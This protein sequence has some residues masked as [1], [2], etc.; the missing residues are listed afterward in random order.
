MPFAAFLVVGEYENQHEFMG[1]SSN[2]KECLDIVENHCK[3]ATIKDIND[4]KDRRCINFNWVFLTSRS[5]FNSKFPM[6]CSGYVIEEIN[7]ELYE[8]Y[9]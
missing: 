4:V 9:C 5:V 1:V 8:Q 2:V 7:P 6:T 3:I